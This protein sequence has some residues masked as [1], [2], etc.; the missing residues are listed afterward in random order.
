MSDFGDTEMV[1]GIMED[2]DMTIRLD[3]GD[4]WTRHEE[5][6]CKP[7]GISV[8][9][10]VTGVLYCMRSDWDSPAKTK[11]DQ[12]KTNSQATMTAMEE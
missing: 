10:N 12:K 5:L 9:T 1:S 6:S 2:P 8:K 3:S 7:Q 4:D 11:V